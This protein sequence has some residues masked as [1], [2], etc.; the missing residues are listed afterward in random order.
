MDETTVGHHQQPL[1]ET[2]NPEDP[3]IR[4][5]PAARRLLDLASAE[6]RGSGTLQE[7]AET[8]LKDDVRPSALRVAE[9]VRAGLTT[10]MIVAA[11]ETA[12]YSPPHMTATLEELP[13]IIGYLQQANDELAR[14][15]RPKI[16]AARDMEYGY[17]DYVIRY[18]DH[19]AMLLNASGPLFGNIYKTLGD[20]GNP[21]LPRERIESFFSDC[22]LTDEALRR[23]PRTVVDSG[24]RGTIGR[25]LS[26]VIR[27][28]QGKD[29][30]DTNAPEYVKNGLLNVKLLS[31]RPTTA[32][33]PGPAFGT[34]ILDS[35]TF[36][37]NVR[38]GE[39]FPKTAAF[40]GRDRLE[41]LKVIQPSA[42]L[43]TALQLL[44]HHTHEYSTLIE[45]DGMPV[46]A[47][48]N[49]RPA[50]GLVDDNVDRGYYQAAN[51]SIVNPVAALVVQAEVVRRALEAMQPTS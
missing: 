11:G 9:L 24:F 32:F 45:R 18:P 47:T 49:R 44:P 29:F 46:E 6:T 15:P 7:Q 13:V 3:A 30:D 43:G 33:T 48:S 27:K 36:P 12:G 31:V 25:D 50:P 35:S 10:D 38:N 21:D 28:L 40:I 39:A 20:E 26:N 16:Y 17:D 19:P 5:I 34:E 2:I 8:L 23:Q 1:A 14:D 37:E 42:A 51:V 22:D 41:S 4:A